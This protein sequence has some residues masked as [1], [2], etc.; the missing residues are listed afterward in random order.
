MIKYI[1]FIFALL[2]IGCEKQESIAPFC[3]SGDCNATLILNYP[4][5]ENG[6]YI[7]DLDF[8]EA[9]QLG[10]WPT[11]DVFI[12]ADDMYP[13]LIVLHIMINL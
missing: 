5:D 4:Q 3:I 7:V 13:L 12:E 9:F 8:N 1:I 10:S 6:Y 2:N 11:F